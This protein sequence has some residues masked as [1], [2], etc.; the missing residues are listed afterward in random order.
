[1]NYPFTFCLYRSNISQKQK[2]CTNNKQF[3]T[4]KTKLKTRQQLDIL[5]LQQLLPFSSHTF[6]H[7]FH[8]PAIGIPNSELCIF[9]NGNKTRSVTPPLMLFKCLL[10]C[11]FV[12]KY[13]KWWIEKTTKLH[14]WIEKNNKT[15]EIFIRLYK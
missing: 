4:K 13:N 9:D 6:L 7:S 14:R 15:A 11:L 2:M 12:C 3:W 1:M 10:D 8:G 5:T